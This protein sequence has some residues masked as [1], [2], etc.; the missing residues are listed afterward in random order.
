MKNFKYQKNGK[1][2]LVDTCMTSNIILATLLV[3][4]SSIRISSNVGVEESII[5]VLA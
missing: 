1:N 4:V 2:S 5:W 3:L